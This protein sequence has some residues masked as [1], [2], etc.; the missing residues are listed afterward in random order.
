LHEEPFQGRRGIQSQAPPEELRP[1]H[2][3][4]STPLSVTH[5]TFRSDWAQFPGGMCD[6]S[7][8]KRRFRGVSLAVEESDLFRPINGDPFS[9]P[10]PHK[11]RKRMGARCM[12]FRLRRLD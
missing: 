4:D 12:A 6:L 9:H 1:Y 7:H 8:L 5:I 2:F 10:Y 11:T 3:I